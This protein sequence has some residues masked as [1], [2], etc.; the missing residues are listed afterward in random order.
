M[1]YVVVSIEVQEYKLTGC[2]SSAK[3]MYRHH[4]LD[5]DNIYKMKNI[6]D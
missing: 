6:S 3:Y 2:Q 1:I 4:L 5:L